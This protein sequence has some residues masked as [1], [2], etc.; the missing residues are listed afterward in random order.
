MLNS[1][2]LGDDIVFLATS[3]NVPGP[4]DWIMMQTCFG[5]HF[6]LFLEK[7]ETE[8]NETDPL[9]YS[10]VQLIGTRKQAESFVCRQAVSD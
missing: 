6:V 5:Y 10:T 2:S 7:Q 8:G 1:V 9:F 3:V 4:V